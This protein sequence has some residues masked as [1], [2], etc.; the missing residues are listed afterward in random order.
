MHRDIK[1][2]DGCKKLEK[3]RGTGSCLISIEFQF[4]TMKSILKMDD[5]DGC[6]I[7]KMYLISLNSTLKMVKMVFFMLCVFYHHLKKCPS[8]L[9]R[10]VIQEV[11]N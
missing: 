3:D 6:T 2:N 11:I 8:I 9:H 4:C 7:M 5:G 1:Q 10:N